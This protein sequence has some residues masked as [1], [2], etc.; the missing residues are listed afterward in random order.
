M[1]GQYRVPVGDACQAARLEPGFLLETAPVTTVSLIGY[2]V[3]FVALFGGVLLLD[4]RIEPGIVVGGALIIAGM[5]IT[6]RASRAASSQPTA[7]GA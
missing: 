3:P 1:Q 5:V 6:D 4:E 7:S 2:L